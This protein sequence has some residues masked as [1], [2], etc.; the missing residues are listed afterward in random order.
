MARNEH[1]G[2]QQKTRA[3]SEE[4][5]ANWDKIFGKKEETKPEPAQKQDV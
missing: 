3:P 1:T 4:Y 2:D 5:R